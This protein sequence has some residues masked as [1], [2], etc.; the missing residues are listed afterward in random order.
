MVE[1]TF[2]SMANEPN[3]V[4]LF[5]MV[6]GLFIAAALADRVIGDR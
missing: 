6:L 4:W 5:V 1:F 2:A 3:P